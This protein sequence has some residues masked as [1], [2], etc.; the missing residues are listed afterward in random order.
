MSVLRIMN[1][2]FTWHL[3]SAL[4]AKLHP[5][6]RPGSLFGPPIVLAGGSVTAVSSCGPCVE[7]GI[8]CRGSSNAVQMLRTTL[9]V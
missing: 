7:P 6:C 8:R 5:T 1:F 9:V 4:C 2:A 3:K